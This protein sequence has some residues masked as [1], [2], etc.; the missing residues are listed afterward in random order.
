MLVEIQRGIYDAI[1]KKEIPLMA[2]DLKEPKNRPGFKIYVKPVKSERMNNEVRVTDYEIMVLYYAR[3]IKDYY[4]EHYETEEALEELLLGVVELENGVFIEINDVEFE[5]EG[6]LL[7]AYM[8]TTV[9]TRIDSE[10]DDEVMEELS[11]N[12]LL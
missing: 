1:G 4:L 8:N 2:S 5:S 9:D 6:D 12:L 10:V 7:A 3:D 11:L